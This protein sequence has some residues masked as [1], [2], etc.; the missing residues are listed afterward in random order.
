MS[1]TMNTPTPDP[2]NASVPGGDQGTL[3]NGEN[4]RKPAGALSAVSTII[5]LELTG[6][7]R[8]KKW[9]ILMIVW[10]VVLVV[11]W[12]GLTALVS[13]AVTQYNADNTPPSRLQSWVFSPILIFTLGVSLVVAP[14]LTAT[15]INGDRATANLAIL[16]VTPITP[17]Q[18]MWGKLLAAWIV[19]GLFVLVGGVPLAVIVGLGGL[20]WA[21][22]IKAILVM[23]FEVFVGC[24][25]GLG[26]SAISARPVTS[27]L[28]TYLVMVAL[29][30]GGPMTYAF[31][32]SSTN[33][34]V[35]YERT[36][37]NY[38]GDGDPWAE[39]KEPYEEYPGL[40]KDPG[41][42]CQKVS[43]SETVSHED[44]IW[45]LLMTSPVGVLADGAEGSQL[46]RWH[47]RHS[48]STVMPDYTVLGYFAE[49]I[50]Q[51]RTPSTPAAKVK[52]LITDVK[53]PLISV[54]DECYVDEAGMIQVLH[55]DYEQ[56]SKVLNEGYEERRVGYLGHSWYWG[57]LLHVLL[58]AGAL[59]TAW[60]RLRTPVKRL[61]KGIRIA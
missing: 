21:M 15:T 30:I 40:N 42:K 2:A 26:I 57:A 35:P 54:Y 36:T 24:A 34:S 13:D 4:H 43:M 38:E 12:L 6:R 60:S 61:P 23:L 48:E 5:K 39:S 49:G 45:W 3:L 1:E 17:G 18:L 50:A 55:A 22:F 59:W 28:V 19:S 10:V 56:I 14:A 37:L 46:R 8:S 33:E 7:A 29:M 16:Q 9:I 11:M 52:E 32:I 31:L 47:E 25:I 27:V 58:T 53:A 41:W 44:R 20:G 51:A